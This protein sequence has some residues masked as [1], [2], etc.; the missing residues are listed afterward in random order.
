[1][2]RHDLIDWPGI[3]GRKSAWWYKLQLFNPDHNFQQVLYFDL[4]VVIVNNI[5]W[6]CQCDPQYF[7][8]IHDF[9][10]LWKPNWRVLNSSIMYF[11][12]GNFSSVWNDFLH[13]DLQELRRVYPGDQD[14]LTKVLNHR[15]LRFF[16]SNRIKSWRWQIFD[17]GIDITTR[18]AKSPGSGASIPPNTSVIVFHGIPK[19][20]EIQQ[21]VIQ[22]HWQ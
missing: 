8:A 12:S 10:S 22:M 7:W 13:H 18:H 2:I 1:M 5:D 11:D 17:G 6:I 3:K 9:K 14:Y 4:D 15:D 21:S 16:E 20:H 19:P